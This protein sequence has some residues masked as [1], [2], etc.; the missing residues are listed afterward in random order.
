MRRAAALWRDVGIGAATLCAGSL[1]IVGGRWMAVG[2]AL[3]AGSA[4]I[5]FE[6]RRLPQTRWAASAA[7]LVI[8]TL[9]IWRF[10]ESRL[11]IT[12]SGIWFLAVSADLSRLVLRFPTDTSR[13]QQ[14]DLMGRRI[15]HLLLIGAASAA[16][17]AVGR[18]LSFQVRLASVALLAV[19]VV[20]II[21][22]TIVSVAHGGLPSEDDEVGR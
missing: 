4:W 22:R 17:I 19:F 14:R 18:V 20:L 8:G 15:R 16:V 10:S 11:W 7:F 1:H 3:A 5:F 9:L 2:I 13:R 6:R 21:G 12:A